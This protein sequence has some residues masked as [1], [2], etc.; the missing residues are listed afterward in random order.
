MLSSKKLTCKGNLRQVFI[1]VYR[2][3]SGDTV[4]HVGIF[5]PFQRK[6]IQAV[7]CW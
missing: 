2:L 6:E 4:S 1:R 5:D 3:N 7:C